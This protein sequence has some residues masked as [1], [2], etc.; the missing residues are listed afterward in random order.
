MQLFIS[1]LMLLMWMPLSCT[2]SRKESCSS[3]LSLISVVVK[4]RHAKHNPLALG[5]KVICRAFSIT[6]IPKFNVVLF[7]GNSFTVLSVHGSRR[8]PYS[9]AALLFCVR[10]WMRHSNVYCIKKLQLERYF[11]RNKSKISV[12]F[13]TYCSISSL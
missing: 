3:T 8:N 4:C 13:H 9:P 11:Q 6:F 7:C 12:F 10:D 2:A 5:K 1:T